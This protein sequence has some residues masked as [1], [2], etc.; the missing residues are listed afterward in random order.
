MCQLIL[1]SLQ[2][3]AG[4]VLGIVYDTSPHSLQPYLFCLWAVPAI[5]SE[6]SST[7]H[8]PVHSMICT[9]LPT[10]G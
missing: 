9:L 2:F 10:V 6:Y 4:H 1:L 5:T 7:Y 8:A 3:I